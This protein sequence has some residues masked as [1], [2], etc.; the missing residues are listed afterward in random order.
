[1]DYPLLNVFWSVF[2]FF[3]WVMWLV[4]LFRVITD[5]FR[6][7]TLGGWPKAA[8]LILVLIVP[9]L[10]VFVYV[11]VRG[12]EMGRREAEHSRRSREEFR[13]YVQ[14]VAGGT[15]GA[16]EL[17]KLAELRKRGDLTEEEFRQAKSRAL[18][19]H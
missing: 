14:E 11:C 9:F 6:D 7:D 3:L 13:E 12:H 10:G 2:W 4:L 17:M 19:Q 18:A 5:I 8:W 16:D 1:M 15:G